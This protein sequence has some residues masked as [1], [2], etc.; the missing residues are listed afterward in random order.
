MSTKSH[1]PTPG[2]SSMRP[3]LRPACMPRRRTTRPPPRP[4]RPRPRTRACGAAR[5]SRACPPH[6]ALRAEF[7]WEC[8]FSCVDRA[9][10]TP[11]SAQTHLVVDPRHRDARRAHRD[12]RRVAARQQGR[13]GAGRARAPRERALWV[14]R[15]PCTIP[16]RPSGES[17]LRSIVRGT[18]VRRSAPRGTAVCSAGELGLPFFCIAR[19][20]ERVVR[21]RAGSASDRRVA[22]R[23]QWRSRRRFGDGFNRDHA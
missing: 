17:P 9:D 1:P 3:S 20:F 19:E 22:C 5:W 21:L 16:A 10:S 13:G 14:E 11:R 7:P 4:T 18:L 6:V 23:G 2:E 12:A 15:S 8:L